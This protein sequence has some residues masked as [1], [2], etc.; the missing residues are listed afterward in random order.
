MTLALNPMPWLLILPYLVSL[1][2]AAI[3]IGWAWP[4]RR[5]QAAGTQVFLSLSLAVVVW[6][7][8][9]VAN[10][11]AADLTLKLIW[12]RLAY[13]A[14]G[15]TVA[16]WLLLAYQF[17]GRR[18]PNALPLLLLLEPILV[19]VVVWWPRL[20]PLFW[21]SVSLQ[22]QAGLALVILN[23]GPLFWIHAAYSYIAIAWA[24][25]V[26]LATIR[27]FPPLYQTQGLVLLSATILPWGANLLTVFGSHA[28]RTIDFTPIALALALPVLAWAL[29][30]FRRA[31]LVPV[32]Y[33]T[34]IETMQAG[35]IILDTHNRVAAI[36]QQSLDDLAAHLPS[37]TPL[38]RA[39]VIGQDVAQLFA[40]WPELVATYV[41]QRHARAEIVLPFGEQDSLY[42]LGITPLF[43]PGGEFAGRVLVIHDLS[44]YQ[45]ARQALAASEQRYRLLF[46]DST[47]AIFVHTISGRILDCNRA[48]AELFGISK[49][50][51]TTLSVGDII[52]PDIFPQVANP[53]HTDSLGTIHTEALG[54]RQ[55]GE[56][57]PIEIHTR[58][59]DLDAKPV[60]LAFIQ[61][62]TRRKTGEL[63]L[64]QTLA[65][66][67]ALYRITRRL[68]AGEELAATLQAAV[69]S[70]ASILTAD[71]VLLFVFDPQDGPP[72]VISWG[73]DA[74]S[75]AAIAALLAD[76]RLAETIAA[77]APRRFLSSPGAAEDGRAAAL[78]CP[79]CYQQRVLG[80]I[81]ASSAPHHPAFSARDESLML[82]VADQTA[83]AIATDALITAERRQRLH[84]DTL[85]EVAAILIRTTDLA[86]LLPD[87]LAHL[88]RLIPFVSAS[89]ML[90]NG[91]NLSIVA[92][93]HLHSIQQIVS[94]PRL[95]RLPHIRTVL[96]GAPH[97]IADC[98]TEPT[99]DTF[100][101]S[102]YI[103]SWMGVPIM[104]SAQIIGLINLDHTTP[105]FFTPED[106]N[107]AVA[108]ANLAG[109]AI[110]NSRSLADVARRAIV[111]E[112][113]RQ[114]GS[115]VLESLDLDEAFERILVQ[116][117]QVLPYDSASIQLMRDGY[118]EIVG[119]RGWPEP[120]KI[121]GLH[122][123]IPGENPNTA[124]LASR[125][126]LRVD[127]EHSQWP[128]FDENPTIPI[129]SWLGMPLIAHGE[130]IGMMTVDSVE[131][132]FFT[133]EHEHL[134]EAFADQVAIAIENAR[135]FHEQEQ[136]VQELD[137]LR[138]TLT[139]ISAELELP[140][141]LQAILARATQ[142]IGALGGDLGL[143][144]EV[145]Q[146]IEIVATYNL[147]HDSTGY[148]QSL[149]E[150]AMGQVAQTLLPFTID[151]YQSWEGR[152]PRYTWGEWH[153]V[154][155]VPLL[156]A[157]KLV[158]VIGLTSTDRDRRF[159]P[160][161]VHLL[162]LF[163]QGAAI[164]VVNARLFASAR[165]AS[166]R[167]A[168]LHRVSQQIVTAS[169]NET[170]IYAAIHDAATQLMPSDQFSIILR[171]PIGPTLYTAYLI[172]PFG[173]GQ[174]QDEPLTDEP[175]TDEPLIRQVIESGQSLLVLDE[176]S[177]R[178]AGSDD[179]RQTYSA[180]AVPMLLGGEVIGMLLTRSFQPRA[181]SAEDRLLLEM[182][183]SYAATA[184][185][186]GRLLAEVQR[187]AITDPLTGLYNR[188]HLFDLGQREFARA[189]R[190]ERPLAAVMIDID[191]FKLVNDTY[192]HSVGD[193]ILA[194][195]SQL[196]QSL[197]RE[198][199]ILGRYGGE[200]F[201]LILPETDSIHAYA[202]AERLR[203][204]IEAM[205][206][207]TARGPVSV[208]ASLGIA[209]LNGT[210]ADL[211][212][213]IAQADNLL[214]QAKDAGRNRVVSDFI[215]PA[216]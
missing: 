134:A 92:H 72:Q 5:S 180:L 194:A 172:D 16:L 89:L 78:F 69:D 158:G 59:I 148:R 119:G 187:L 104:A 38:S 7:L 102:E 144:D 27:R 133:A 60:V 167:R 79:I 64:R 151:D 201:T 94:P 198:V 185:D 186:N 178:G 52:P 19:Q 126:P 25:W 156:A 57:F 164:A 195:M 213:L 54:L 142:L 138:A 135:L 71:Q 98:Q 205:T 200:E 97:I 179:R 63:S 131:P 182:L 208:T 121:L 116:L 189:R 6:L 21:T 73:Q 100:P 12:A 2:L 45:Q 109:L 177:P 210:A 161:D 68:A 110:E 181:Y 122:L 9:D 184:L 44:P 61:D 123:P 171:D 90:L 128:I 212:G 32:A 192:G 199:D 132:Q 183:A 1:T 107:L 136:R 125:R 87:I 149:G 11:L 22:P 101:G 49:E 115:V 95:N 37:T 168:I 146:D 166:D 75:P 139:E 91:E 83:M 14:I 147:T 4:R 51:A 111:A 120:E 40:P 215:S 93:R 39:A 46:E 207:T 163:A 28:V 174:P 65:E 33:E 197:V 58:L 103:R 145:R 18:I 84:A 70:L 35:V 170:D 42:D 88:E 106:Q 17:N 118:L 206:V 204:Q 41:N 175:L 169:L 193:E 157:G 114:A 8:T 191:N 140:R 216:P 209:H 173:V 112:T 154:L 203:R 20:T 10:L 82:A 105:N 150:G 152:S 43:D 153:A 99:W 74:P 190:F 26:F 130:V 96:G 34:I 77:G 31:A 50:E 141:L 127:I 160:T 117:A 81:Q 55:S 188:R 29:F 124:V 15:S 214:Y 80:M 53:Q 129:R 67:E 196:L 211:A 66:T 36:N 202:T 143:Y 48:A 86:Q 62:I 13:S 47:D 24:S 113:L 159:G 3:C 30:S 155:A 108:L 23:K 85:R 162:T 56:I 76:P 137:A 176:P 165:D